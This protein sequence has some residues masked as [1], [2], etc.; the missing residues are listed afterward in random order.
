M[1]SKTPPS[2]FGRSQNAWEGTQQQPAVITP[3][4]MDAPAPIVVTPMATTTPPRQRPSVMMML[5]R[6]LEII[7]SAGAIGF[8]AGATPYSGQLSPF[9]SS[10]QAQALTYAIYALG[11]LTGI[12]ALSWF[13]SDIVKCCIPRAAQSRGVT[14]LVI[15]IDL[16]LCAAWLAVII[17]MIA[18]Y[19]CA[20]GSLNG[21]CNW[22]NTSLFFGILDAALLLFGIAWLM[23]CGCC[24]RRT[25]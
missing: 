2:T 6:L 24:C 15:L 17:V 11:G 20:P 3:Q 1:S 19:T 23:C 13:F 25:G 16:L 8:L 18:N 4:S 14:T 22:F 21:Y 9:S 5:L 12:W 10:S 7:A